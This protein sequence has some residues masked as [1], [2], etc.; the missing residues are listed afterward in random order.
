MS[1]PPDSKISTNPTTF[2]FSGT[3]LLPE[4]PSN[5]AKR[6]PQLQLLLHRQT[7]RQTRPHQKKKDN[8]ENFT[9]RRKQNLPAYLLTAKYYSITKKNPLLPRKFISRFATRNSP[10]ANC[11]PFSSRRSSPYEEEEE[12]RCD[13][14]LLHQICVQFFPFVPYTLPLSSDLRGYKF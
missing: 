5:K 7:D 11:N 1:S 9:R 10:F 12:E 14:A 13:F 2:E 3:Q 8:Y 6:Y 4:I